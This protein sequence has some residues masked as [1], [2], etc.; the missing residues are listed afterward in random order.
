MQQPEMANDPRFATPQLR[1]ANDAALYAIMRPAIKAETSAV[2][3]KRFTEAG[4]M[5]ERLN[6]Y[7]E[8]MNQPQVRETGLI[9]WLKQAGVKESVPV[10]TLPGTPRPTDGTPRA[11]APVP[12]QHT[13]AI[14][15]EHGYS[16]A[17]IEAL[18]SA[19]TV[20]QT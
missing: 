19:G 13:R 5:H 14:L 10:P 4:L 8:F 7:A 3:G 15:S 18:L 1:L 11:I 2:W 20:V 6:S 12:G 17:D 16:A 9:Q